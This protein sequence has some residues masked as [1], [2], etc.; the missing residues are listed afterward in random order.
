MVIAKLCSSLPPILTS[1]SRTGDQPAVYRWVEGTRVNNYAT[2]ANAWLEFTQ[3][4]AFVE[5]LQNLVNDA[6][7]N[8][9]DRAAAVEEF[10]LQQAVTAGV[11]KKIATTRPKN[12]NKW[13]KTLAPWFNEECREAKKGLAEARRMYGKGDAHIVDALRKY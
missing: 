4:P 9:E 3:R 8:N 7:K 6:G 10:V 1:K 13:G 11:V 5:G 12:P 2:S